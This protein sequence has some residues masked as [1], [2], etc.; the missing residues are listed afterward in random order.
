VKSIGKLS[1]KNTDRK[2]ELAILW[3][4]CISILPIESLDFSFLSV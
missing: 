3:E 4:S 2:E 1:E